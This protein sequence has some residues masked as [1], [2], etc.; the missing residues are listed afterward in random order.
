MH[1]Y[2]GFGLKIES[3]VELK[4]LVADVFEM[5]DVHIDIGG[6]PEHLEHALYADEICEANGC[7]VLLRIV[8]TGSFYV[9]GGVRICMSLQMDCEAEKARLFLLGT[10]MGIVL[11]QRGQVPLHAGSMSKSGRTLLVCGSSGAGKSTLTRSGLNRGY[12]MLSDDIS[13]LFA[14]EGEYHVAP[15]FP[16]QKLWMDGIEQYALGDASPELILRRIDK[17]H[18]DV[19]ERFY[20]DA[21]R[22]DV[23]VELDTHEGDAVIV[24]TLTGAHALLVLVRHTYRLPFIELMGLGQWH[25]TQCGRIA[26][27]IRVLRVKRPAR[28]FTAEAQ[29]AA[30][31]EGL[32]WKEE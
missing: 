21:A 28:G 11:M 6:V 20:P 31:E 4:E 24:E 15:S 2:K 26:S 17:Y 1:R 9:Q 22:I 13:A 32:G 25:F 27:Q 29:W 18:V 10:M 14:K 7:E 19:G 3:A 30:I 23:L 12:R 8:D 16:K 5:S